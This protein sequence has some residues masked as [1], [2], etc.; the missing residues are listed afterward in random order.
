MRCKKSALPPPIVGGGGA[1]ITVW[2]VKAGDDIKFNTQGSYTID[3][4]DGSVEQIEYNRQAGN[5]RLI[6]DYVDAGEY[7][8]SMSAGI[9]AFSLPLPH[10]HPSYNDSPEKLIEI[11]Q[12]GA[13]KWQTMCEMFVNAQNMIC[14]ATDTPDLSKVY[15]VDSMFME[16]YRFNSPIEHWDF[17]SV[18]RMSNM[19]RSA[20]TFNQS[21]TKIDLRDVED[22][23]GMLMDT[24]AFIQDL[25]QLKLLNPQLDTDNLFGWDRSLTQ[26]N[27][28][29]AERLEAEEQQ[30]EV[31]NALNSTC[32]VLRP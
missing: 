1:F 5:N 2:K 17:S 14:S 32:R 6:H 23:D 15:S 27:E 30:Q 7:T 11:K 26:Y 29:H 9:T 28:L 21:L 31:Y 22:V 13:A 3:W 19:L 10:F 25:R 20:K 8:V 16:C 24:P 18:K 4:G 12:W